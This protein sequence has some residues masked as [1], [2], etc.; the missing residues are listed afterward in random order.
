M[1]K[2]A[3]MFILPDAAITLSKSITTT[4]L[5]CLPTTTMPRFCPSVS[6]SPSDLSSVFLN[7][8]RVGVTFVPPGHTWHRC[9]WTLCW[10]LG[11]SSPR[12]PAC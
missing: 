8:P 3:R 10:P 2:M 11:H 4:V 9:S 1:I 12:M 6:G 5:L 7:H